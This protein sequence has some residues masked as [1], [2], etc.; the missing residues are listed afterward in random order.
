M[1]FKTNILL[2]LFTASL[3]GS[4]IYWNID[5]GAKLW[6]YRHPDK[7]GFRQARMSRNCDMVIAGQSFPHL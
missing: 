5:T 6:G 2:I 1:V 7:I 3:D 4:L